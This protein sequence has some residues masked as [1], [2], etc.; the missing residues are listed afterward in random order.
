[1]K[2][3]IAH[4]SLNT[5]GYINI[6]EETLTDGSKVYNITLSDDDGMEMEIYNAVDY[7]D[8]WKKYELLSENF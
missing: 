5:E 1:M 2:K 4:F 7:A 3:R 6:I 8:C